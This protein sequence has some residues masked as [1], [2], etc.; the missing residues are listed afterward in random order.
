MKLALVANEMP[1]S[2]LSFNSIDPFFG[3]LNVRSRGEEICT[4][5]C[6]VFFP[7]AYPTNLNH[8]KCTSTRSTPGYDAGLEGIGRQY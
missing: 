6:H 5:R 1:A 7:V 4:V 3:N 2:S 8:P